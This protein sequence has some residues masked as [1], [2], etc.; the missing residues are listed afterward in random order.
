MHQQKA[1]HFAPTAER[2]Y[3]AMWVIKGLRNH[4]KKWHNVKFTLVPFHKK[5]ESCNKSTESQRLF[6][7]SCVHV[8]GMCLCI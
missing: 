6:T 2:I 4:V 7:K 3:V 8:L 1:D 5:Y